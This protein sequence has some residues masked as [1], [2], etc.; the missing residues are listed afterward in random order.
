MGIKTEARRGRAC[1]RS[2]EV[3]EP[4]PCGKGGAP[5]T[6]L[7]RILT[8]REVERARPNRKNLYRIFGIWTGIG[9]KHQI[10]IEKRD[11]SSVSS[12]PVLGTGLLG[13]CVRFRRGNNNV[14]VYPFKLTT[15]SLAF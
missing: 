13:Y 14:V 10:K 5:L 9:V 1:L 4:I 15:F 11:L 6:F 2:S 12:D 7:P 8:I 3:M